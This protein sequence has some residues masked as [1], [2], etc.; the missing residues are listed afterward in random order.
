MTK[1]SMNTAEARPTPNS[2]ITRESPSTN[3]AKTHTMIVAAAVITRPVVATPSTTACDA[4]RRRTHSSCTRD[5]RK[6]S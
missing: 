6:T 5:M 2:L 3:E 4:S 1:A